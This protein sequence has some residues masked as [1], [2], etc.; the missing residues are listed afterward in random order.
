MTPEPL[1]TSDFEYD[2]PPELI[3]QAPLMD[4]AGSRLLVL[5]RHDRRQGSPDRRQAPRGGVL[6]RRVSLLGERVPVGPSALVDSLFTELPSLIPPGDLLI[7]DPTKVRHARL[8]GSRSSAAPAEVLLIQPGVGRHLD[9]HGQAGD[10]LQPGK[11]V[12]IRARA[13]VETVEVLADGNRLVR[14]LGVTAEEAMTRHGR[15]PLPPYITRAPTELD[16]VRYQTVYARQEG[17]IAAPTVGLHF[18]GAMLD[19]LSARGYCSW[20]RSRHRAGHFQAGRVGRPIPA[21]HASRSL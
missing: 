11:R 2:L 8:V 5:L 4:R 17:S 13:W 3:A 20:A 15:V 10:A 9:R 1:R 21:H 12:E 16:E 19:D 18:T 6:P 7:L 14:F